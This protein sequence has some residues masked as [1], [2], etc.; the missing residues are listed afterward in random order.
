MAV[1]LDMSKAYDRVEWS[2][3]EAIM[4][5]MGFHCKWRNWIMECVRIV[6]YSFSI[7]G[8]VK[9]YVIPG[10][11]IRQ[12][13]PLSPYLF[14]LCSEGFSSLLR[15]AAGNKR[16]SGMRICRQGPSLT[17]LFFADDSL[18]F[19]K[20]N[21][22]Q[23]IELMRVLQVYAAAS[24]QLINLD[25]SSIL[26]SKNMCPHKKHQICHIIEKENTFQVGVEVQDTSLPILHNSDSYPPVLLQEKTTF[27][28]HH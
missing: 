13:D 4:T 2:F 14:L 20:A 6:T 28:K 15:Q 26:F 11:G 22:Q 8:D 12:G 27:G 10:R 23:A 7:N 17:H 9:E 1:K 5:K 18:I 21:E 3:L 24:G 16:I 19:C 25:K